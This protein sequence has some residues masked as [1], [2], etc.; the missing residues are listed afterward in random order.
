MMK[1]SSSTNIKSTHVLDYDIFRPLLL[2]V[3]ETPLLKAL[4]HPLGQHITCD[5]ETNKE[6]KKEK[7]I[8]LKNVSRLDIP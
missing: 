1:N 4:T 2:V 8:T 5:Q 7:T 6:K 3:L